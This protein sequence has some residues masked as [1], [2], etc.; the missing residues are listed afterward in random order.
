MI[1]EFLLINKKLFVAF[2][3]LRASRSKDYYLFVM[4]F[5][6]EFN[7]TFELSKMT[8]FFLVLNVYIFSTSIQNSK[9]RVKSCF[10]FRQLQ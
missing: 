5:L 9:C 2:L 7:F 1:G 8:N 6:T 10:N 4:I 3:T